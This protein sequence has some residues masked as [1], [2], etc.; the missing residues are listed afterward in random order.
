MDAVIVGSA[1]AAIAQDLRSSS[2]ESFWVGTSFFLSQAI[3]IPLYGTTSE[4][5]GR[6]WPI[7]IAL[8]IFHIGSILCATAQTITWL[9]S[10]RVVQGMRAGG[11]IQLVQVILSDILMMSKR[12][13][14]MAIA[15]FAWSLG[16]NIGIPIGGA[17][18]ER[19]SWRWIFYINIPVYVVCIMRLLYAMQ[20]QHDM[21]LFVKKLGM[22]DWF[23]G[24]LQYSVLHA[25][26]ETIACIAYST[27]AGLV[28]AW[29]SNAPSTLNTLP[30]WD[31]LS[32][33][34]E[35]GQTYVPPSPPF[36]SHPLPNR[37]L[38]AEE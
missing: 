26:L 3:T 37:S 29:S 22:L 33:Q 5:F 4:I 23:F 28:A 16:T 38:P 15:A 18:G 21:L 24:A 8:S 20:L 17:I 35:W 32:S 25:S 1:P 10:A 12:G 6:K 11:M 31:G 13:L 27:R 34:P 19:T 36:S 7:L 14:Y 9:I 2:V 30:W